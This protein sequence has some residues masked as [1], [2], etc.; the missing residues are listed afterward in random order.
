MVA[1]KTLALTAADLF[2]SPGLVARAKA[3]FDE[4]TRGRPYRS[5]FPEDA[6]PALP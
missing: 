4:A 2:Y 3:G 5:L 1:A 6:K